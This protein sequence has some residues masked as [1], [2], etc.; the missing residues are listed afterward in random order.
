[1]YSSTFAQGLL[2][3]PAVI[4]SVALALLAAAGGMM[5]SLSLIHI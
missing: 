2:E 3:K 5:W 4:V 1:M